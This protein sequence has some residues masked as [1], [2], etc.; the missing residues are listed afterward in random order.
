MKSKLLFLL[1]VLAVSFCTALSTVRAVEAMDEKS[2]QKL[3]KEVG[4]TSKSMKDNATT[5]NAEVVQKDATRVAE[6][7]TQMAGFWKA[8]NT[9]DAVKWSTESATAAK[10]A[11]AAAKAGDWELV[12]T[13][14]GG[15]GKNCKACHEK[16]QDKQEDGSYKFK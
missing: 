15:V 12:K 16:H 7:Y 3:M 11:A 4:K 10:A 5:K 2:F 13:S 8:R 6:I 9:E 14:W 1:A